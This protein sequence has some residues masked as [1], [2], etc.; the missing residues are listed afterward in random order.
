MCVNNQIRLP[1]SPGWRVACS[2]LFLAQ[3][4]TADPGCVG[5]RKG[6]APSVGDS[7]TH[8]APPYPPHVER[9]CPVLLGLHS[10]PLS[11]HPPT[12]ADEG[13]IPQAARSG[14]CDGNANS[15][16][17]PAHWAGWRCPAVV[18]SARCCAWGCHRHTADRHQTAHY[19]L[20]Q[21]RQIL[22]ATWG[23]GLVASAVHSLRPRT[24]RVQV[25]YME[26]AGAYAKGVLV[27]KASAPFMI[28]K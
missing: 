25:L 17:R 22:V 2:R 26:L 8:P 21:I 9:W 23:C 19:D 13:S 11:E 20:R 24:M 14:H 10:P 16:L 12:L 1:T 28:L 27:Y 15:A 4:D 18:H 7:N 6:Q 5:H 3:L